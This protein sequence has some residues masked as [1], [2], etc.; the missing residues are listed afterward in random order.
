MRSGR[1]VTDERAR[2][3]L[4]AEHAEASSELALSVVSDGR[5]ERMV[6]DRTF[7][8]AAGV[9]WVI[10]YKTS[11]HEGGDL[12]AFVESE[13]LRYADQLMRYQRALEQL[14]PGR[15]V[16]AALYFPLLGVFA[17]Y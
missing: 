15:E 4:S 3:I 16:R 2:W 17:E 6:I 1:A 7:I 11:S 14:E 9:R 10:D 5:V 12:A 13:K 8:D